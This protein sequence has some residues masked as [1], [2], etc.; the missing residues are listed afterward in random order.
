MYINIKWLTWNVFLSPN[1]NLFRISIFTYYL[2]ILTPKKVKLYEAYL[3]P[4]EK[5]T[6]V[7]HLSGSHKKYIERK[8]RKKEAEINT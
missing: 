2:L 1:T 8:K 6:W 7:L 4:I 3:C 5:V